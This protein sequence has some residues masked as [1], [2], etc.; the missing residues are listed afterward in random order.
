MNG[1]DRIPELDGLR[2]IAIGLVLFYHYFVV[3]SRFRPGTP[4]SYLL[5]LGRLSWSGVDLFFVLSAFLIGGILIDDS[6]STND[7]AVFYASRF[8]RILPF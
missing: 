4:L 1:H 5:A 6:H 2:G 7:F 3:I 8:L